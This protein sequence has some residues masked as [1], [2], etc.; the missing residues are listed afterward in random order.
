FSFFSLL[1]LR[2]PL[3]TLFPYT[4]LFRSSPIDNRRHLSRLH[5]IGQDRH[6]LLIKLCEVTDKFLA[7]EA[8]TYIRVEFAHQTRR[9]TIVPPCSSD[10]S[11]DANSIW[12]Q[13]TTAFRERMVSNEVEDQV[14]ALIG[15]GEIL[16]R[17]INHVVCTD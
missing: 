1:I 6:V 11:H 10:P 2:P 13:N 16:F 8:R 9:H 5:E 3:S 17:V 4:T 15:F 14:V 12:V 7:N